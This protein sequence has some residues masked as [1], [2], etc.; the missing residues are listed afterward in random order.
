MSWYHPEAIEHVKPT[1]DFAEEFKLYEFS[2][3][4]DKDR[5]PIFDLQYRKTDFPA[6]DMIDWMYAQ[7]QYVM[8]DDDVAEVLFSVYHCQIKF[9]KIDLE[10]FEWLNSELNSSDMPFKFFIADNQVT[11]EPVE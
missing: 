9:K 7:L 5:N 6:I 4:F 3:T 10:K 8:N 2:V 1:L 11:L